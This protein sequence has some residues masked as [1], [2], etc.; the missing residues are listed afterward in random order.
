MTEKQLKVYRCLK[1]FGASTP[2]AVAKK[3]GYT[4]SAW[5][6]QQLKALKKA[7]LIDSCG[8]AKTK[9]YFITHKND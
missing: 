2:R 3:L 9:S 8:A 1:V 5:I 4:E 6:C 7:G